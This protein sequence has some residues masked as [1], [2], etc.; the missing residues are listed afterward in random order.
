M[1]GLPSQVD[2]AVIGAGAA[3]IGAARRLREAG[4]VSL[5]VLEARDRVG[6]RVNTI[7]RP[8]SRSIAVPNG[9]LGD[10]TRSPLSPKA[11]AFRSTVGR[12]NGHP[13]APQRRDPRGGSRLDRDPRSPIAGRR[14]AAVEP[15]DRSL[16]SL[17]VPGERWNELL[18][19]TS[20]WGTALSSIACL[21]KIMSA[22]R[23][24]GPT[25]GSM[26]GM[27]GCSRISPKGCRWRARRRCRG[28]TIA[29]GRSGS[30]PRAGRLARH[31]WSSRYDLHHRRRNTPLRP[32]AAGQD[33]GCGR[34]AARVDDKLFI[35]LGGALPARARCLPRRLDHFSGDHELPGAAFRPAGDLLLLRRPL[36]SGARSGREAR[37]SLSPRRARPPLWQR[38]PHAAGTARRHR[39][40]ARPVGARF[41]FLCPS[42]PCR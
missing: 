39:L 42:R 4:V 15:M 27:A 35:S 17:L 20:T 19:A 41:L 30:R 13:A 2:V 38:C 24:A 14:K 22:T 26:R 31:G 36:R 37:C 10:R 6:G 11:S 3:G 12:R 18:D 5:L 16:A 9:A 34:P 23:I 21:S 8:D 28:S 32:A 25:G 33:R 7:E 40:V 1:T 29:D